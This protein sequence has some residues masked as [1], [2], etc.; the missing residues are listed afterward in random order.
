MLKL[1]NRQQYFKKSG[2]YIIESVKNGKKYVGSA[3]NLYKRI[4]SHVNDLLKNKHTNKK[5]QSHF[6]K[7]GPKSLQITVVKLCETKM[8]KSWEI[9]FMNK[10]NSIN[11]GFNYLIPYS[12]FSGKCLSTTHKNNIRKSHILNLDKNKPLLLKNLEIARQKLSQMREDGVVFTSPTKGKKASIETRIKLSNAKKGKRRNL[13][14]EQRAN[15]GVW[16]VKNNSGSKSHFA[17]LDE[18]KVKNIRQE[19]NNGVK[20]IILAKKYNI[21]RSVISQIKN[22]QIWK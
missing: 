21:S 16:A 10:Y 9:F 22:N 20:G 14:A 19:L 7:Y 12:G 18:Q 8:M 1:I 6:N 2:I 5:L 15:I 17:K 11:K 3:T 13:S 4:N